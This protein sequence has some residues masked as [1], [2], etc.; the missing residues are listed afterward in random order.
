LIKNQWPF[1]DLKRRS[2]KGKFLCLLA[3]KRS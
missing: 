3:L 1:Q 2:T